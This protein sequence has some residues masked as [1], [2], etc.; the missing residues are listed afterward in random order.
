M[1]TPYE[2]L[3]TLI[4]ICIKTDLPVHVQGM[5]GIGKTKI[6]E[7]LAR[8]FDA[9]LAV[10]IGSIA[11]PTD[12]GGLPMATPEGVRM[13][14]REWA[15]RL[16]ACTENGKKLGIAFLDEVTTVPPMV[17]AAMLRVVCERWVG[18]LQLAP[19]VR[20]VL[21]SNPPEIAAS[22]QNLAPPLA[23]RMMHLKWTVDHN[24]WCDGMVAGFPD[25]AV[26]VPPDNWKEQLPQQRVLVASY[27]KHVGSEKLIKLPQSPNDQ[28]GAW[29]SPRTWEMATRFLAGCAAMGL[30]RQVES[31]GLA[32]LVGDG[33]AIEF[34]EWKQRLDLPNPEEV[35]KNPRAFKL[36]EKSDRAYAAANSI[37]AAVLSNNTKQRW[38]AA[39]L[40]LAVASAGR[41]DVVTQPCRTLLG[42]GNKPEG[43]QFPDEMRPMYE[44]FVDAGILK[45]AAKSTAKVSKPAKK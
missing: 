37:L 11:D 24:I 44:M 30:G 20:M 38:E 25:V 41:E 21:A 36:P 16:N 43:A 3:L 12:F 34:L 22:G 28:A 5:P 23:N 8:V 15:K 7:M 14:P 33:V 35:L 9:D 13:L 4:G 45:G 27:I 40:A 18:D 19:H 2:L 17:Q 31:A 42:P 26:S 32:G 10:L 39:M 6:L 29:P 1:L